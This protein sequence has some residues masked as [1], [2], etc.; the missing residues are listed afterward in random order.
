[1]NLFNAG[2]FFYREKIE[3]H[4]LR[5]EKAMSEIRKQKTSGEGILLHDFNGVQEY[6][7]FKYEDESV[8]ANKSNLEGPD[9]PRFE[10]PKIDTLEGM[11]LTFQGKRVKIT[12]EEV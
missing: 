5:N 6:I 11:L 4:G 3:M 9:G 7:T 8:S 1:V 2:Y 10:D 12:I